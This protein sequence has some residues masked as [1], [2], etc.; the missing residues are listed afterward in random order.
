M[1]GQR[2]VRASQLVFCGRLQQGK[3]W[4][5]RCETLYRPQMRFDIDSRACAFAFLIRV[6]SF[7]KIMTSCVTRFAVVRCQPACLP[8]PPA[9]KDAPC[10]TYIVSY[11]KR[12]I[13]V[14]CVHSETLCS[15]SHTDY[16][17]LL[18]VCRNRTVL[19]RQYVWHNIEVRSRNRICHMKGIN[20]KF[21]ECLYSCLIRHTESRVFCAVLCCH[22][23]L[24]CSNLF[25]D[26]R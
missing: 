23:G 22:V 12:Q 19:N 11:F 13:H 8:F 16:S 26:A 14:K 10:L 17:H 25:F 5:C 4:K 15:A 7:Y 18:S 21:Y 9:V 6:C 3:P 1:R 20:I 2:T 24:P